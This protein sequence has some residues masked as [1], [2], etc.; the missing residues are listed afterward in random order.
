MEHLEETDELQVA[1]ARRVGTVL[2]G[3]WRLDRVLGVGGMG[4]VYAAVHR[5]GKIA[6]VKV[7]HGFFATNTDARERFKQEAYIANSVQHRGIVSVIDDDVTPEGEPYI[8]MELLEGESIDQRVTRLGGRLPLLEA[9]TCAHH[10]L[11]VLEATHAK[12][13]VH[14]DL[15]PENLFLTREGTLKLLDFGIARLRTDGSES[16][17][18]TRTGML[19]GTPAFMAPEQA[20]ARWSEVDARTDLWAV[21]AIMYVALTGKPVHAGETANEV[22]VYAATKPVPSIARSIQVPLEVVRVVDRALAFD[23]AERFPDAASMRA[24]VDAAIV[25]VRSASTQATLAGPP[26]APSKPPPERVRDESD[27]YDPAFAT[28]E[29]VAALTEMFTLLER[30]LFAGLQ[31]GHGHPEAEKKLV[32]VVDRTIAALAKTDE[33]LAWNVTA[34]GFIARG[35]TIWEPRAPH[36]RIPYQLFADGVRSMTLLPGID[37][38]ELRRFIDILLMDRAREVAPEDDFVTLLWDAGFEH[39]AY[40]AIDTFTESDQQQRAAFEEQTRAVVALAHFDTSFQLEDCWSDAHGSGAPPNARLVAMLR[41]GDRADAEAM[42]RAEGMHGASA[43]QAA[44]AALT[45]EPELRTTLGA[46]I[47]LDTSAITPRFARAIALAWNEAVRMGTQ[48]ALIVPLR[49]AVEGLAASSPAMVIAIV[50]SVC[51]AGLDG[52][53]RVAFVSA[54]V[55]PKT[56]ERVLEACAADATRAIDLADMLGFLD[57]SHVGVALAAVATF[58]DGPAKDALLDYLIRVGKGHEQR[59]AG[60]FAEASVEHALAI[61]RVLSK[62]NT[63]DARTAIMRASSSPHAIVRL[64]ALGHVEGVASERLRLELKALLE[65]NEPSVRMGTLRSIQRNR[66]RVA[67]PG[68]VLR[69][70][71]AEFDS[72]PIDERRLSLE[73]LEALAPTRAED[74]CVELLQETRVITTDAHEETRA[75]A[76]SV[77]GRIATTDETMK[78]LEAAAGARWKSSERVRESAGRARDLVVVRLSQPPTSKGAKS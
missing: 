17:K 39:V 18:R 59:L 58:P 64:E 48:N 24:A 20:R 61:I 46:R 33:G 13:I 56:S 65:D 78:A 54:I 14:R 10:M 75:L 34:Y 8:V 35:N 42:V 68:L 57:D 28:N 51:R 62:I 31:Y 21:G 55:S 72:L 76:A 71:S 37:A 23:K 3:K 47:A 30:A 32:L 44:A 45:V 19:M 38:A 16:H 52:D 11:D 74:V 1:A 69:I 5:N 77:L 6:A 15:K 40:Q 60:A 49:A 29:D 43:S 50:T 12:G 36:D 70:K 53:A 27:V 41:G 22:I 66:V 26:P 67:G 25:A 9:L 2:S 7:L 4:A 73:T 63:Q